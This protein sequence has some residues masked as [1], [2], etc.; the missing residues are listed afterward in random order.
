MGTGVRQHD[1][2]DC[3]AACLA[4]ICLRYKLKIP[5]VHLRE[6]MKV[7]KNGASIYAIIQTAAAYHLCGE[8]LFGTWEELK[9]EILA[10]QIKVPFIAHIITDHSLPHF[11]VVDKIAQNKICGFDP[12][13]GRF[14]YSDTEFCGIWTGY[15]ITFEKTE[16][17]IA[18]NQKRGQFRKYLQI[19]S[20][21]KRRYA[22]VM[23]LCFA[24]AIISIACSLAYQQLIDRY[25]LSGTYTGDEATLGGDVY[26]TLLR[27]LEHVFANM[28]SLFAALIC[29]YLV[30]FLIGATR[31]FIVARITKKSMEI[32]IFKYCKHLLSLPVYFFKDRQ[33]GEVISRFNDIDVIQDVLSGAVYTSLLN[34]IM[35][36]AG[37]IVLVSINLK[38]FVIVLLI[39]LIYL[40]IILIYRKPITS[41]SREIMESDAKIVSALKETVDG[42]VT[43]KTFGSEYKFIDRLSESG[44]GL[45]KKSYVGELISASQ[46]NLLM[47]VESLGMLFILWA[48]SMLV[49]KGDMSL[50]SLIA[51]QSLVTFF[52]NPILGLIGLQPQMQ[53][54]FIAAERLNDVLEV[55]PEETEKLKK[56]I[57]GS[58]QN[59][60]VLQNVSFQYGYG[61]EILHDISLELI[62]GEKMAVVGYS[63]GGKT[64]LLQL[65]AS[66]YQ[67]TKGKLF[68]GVQGD[69]NKTLGAIRDQMI[70]ISQKENLFTGTLEDNLLL[71]D[72]KVSSDQKE[73]VLEGC[74]LTQLIDHL[75]FG[76]KT[77]VD[78]NGKNFSEGERQRIALARALLTEPKI[79][80]LDE[81]TSNLDNETEERVID[82]IWENFKQTTCIFATHKASIAER[83]GRV[84]L[85]QDGTIL[86][87]GTHQSLLKECEIY[88]KLMQQH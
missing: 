41:I 48:G 68:Y 7:D 36:I 72:A 56:W 71:Y 77:A 78:E 40:L 21:Q 23:A 80:L 76:I 1:I 45:I 32:L 20:E 47:V 44:Y 14:K 50:G 52:I 19:F 58:R 28:G 55:E 15:I 65:M 73:K 85:I 61:K 62:P 54:A 35:T 26:T 30:Q 34:I 16:Q 4:T 46:T 74:Q 69:Q 60:I 3:G 83:C 18:S 39:T 17:F 66:F 67:P 5:L 57:R 79:L 2:R 87:I 63:G 24:L 82:F 42:I 37:G 13:K 27:Q 25:I 6:K 59:K 9:Q 70:Y 51:F 64:T 12:A 84:V 31:D 22:L 81:S 53:Q 49:I 8:A 29:I 43:I 75:P 38:L 10:G 86:K 33:T 88:E 11:I